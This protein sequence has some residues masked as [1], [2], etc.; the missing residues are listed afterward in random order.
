MPKETE[1]SALACRGRVDGVLFRELNE[2]FRIGLELASQLVSEFLLPNENVSRTKRRGRIPGL[3]V[4]VVFQDLLVGDRWNILELLDELLHHEPTIHVLDLST[5]VRI[6]VEP[7]SNSFLEQKPVEHMVFH[8]PIAPSLV[9]QGASA[10]RQPLE[11]DDEL[12]DRHDVVSVTRGHLSRL[13]GFRGRWGGQGR[14][15]LVRRRR[16]GGTLASRQNHS[17]N[18]TYRKRNT[19]DH[20]FWIIDKYTVRED[21]LGGLGRPEEAR[22]DRLTASGSVRYEQAPVRHSH[23]CGPWSPMKFP[24]EERFLQYCI[25]KR[26]TYLRQLFERR[27][28]RGFYDLWQGELTLSRTRFEVR[29]IP[30]SR[31]RWLGRELR[32]LLLQDLHQVVRNVVPEFTPAPPSVLTR[33]PGAMHQVRVARSM[34]IAGEAGVGKEQLAILLHVLSGRPGALVRVAAAEL[35]REGGTNTRQLIPERGSVFIHDLESLAP[36]AQEELLGFL[37]GEARRRDLLFFVATRAE[38]RELVS[39]HGL[40]RDLFVRVSQTEVR[41]PS[42]EQETDALAEFVADVVFDLVRIPP[43]ELAILREQAEALAIEWQRGKSIP[44]PPGYDFVSEAFSYVLWDARRQR[45]AVLLGP[46]LDK[47]LEGAETAENHRSLS[48]LVIDAIERHR[49]EI[50]RPQVPPEGRARTDVAL[51][52]LPTREMQPATTIPTHLGLDGLLRIYFAE[53]LREEEG[54]L[55]RVARRAGRPLREILS[56]IERLGLDAH[57]P[58]TRDGSRERSIS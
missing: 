13:R 49:D 16:R 5:N 8:E 58:T 6:L 46:T 21:F 39:K 57:R 4:F 23:S 27:N 1:V 36:E 7:S 45:A 25:S 28:P 17:Q 56:E 24:S 33:L 26:R 55:D 47:E 51:A 18:D 3:V 48:A 37:N 44:V 20:L 2:R 14:R 15:R 12:V 29:G 32:W 40:R 50:E 31:S 30:R 35:G 42:V 9:H 52:R 10:R 53:L 41:L 43:E 54:R 22:T 38:P 19:F 11:L 34:L